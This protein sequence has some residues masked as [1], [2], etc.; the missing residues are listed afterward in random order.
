MHE[1]VMQ[2][3][4]MHALSIEN[5]GKWYLLVFFL[6]FYLLPLNFHP[7][8]MPDETRYAEISREMVQSGDWVVP[9]LLGLR[10]FEKPV[11]G[12]WLNNMSQ[13]VFGENS[14]S[15]R[16]IPALMTF[17]SA[18]C[19]YW[20]AMR[21]WSNPRKAFISAFIYLSSFLVFTIGTFN[22]LDPI[23]T[24]WL[25]A[26]MCAFY[27]AVTAQTQKSKLIAYIL[28]GVCSGLG[29]LTKGFLALAVPVIAAG[30]YMLLQRRFIELVKYSLISLVV[31]GVV[32]LPWA[33]LIYRAEEDFW[34]YF[35][36]VEHIKRFMGENAQHKEPPWF[37]IPILFYGLLPWF[38]LLPGSLIKGWKL[39]K[40]NNDQLYL[41]TWCVMPFLFFSASSGKLPTYILPV[42]A[43]LAL[44]LGNVLIEAVQAENF[45]SIRINSAI[46]F[47]LGGLFF[48]FIF[49]V[50]FTYIDSDY[51]YSEEEHW[52]LFVALGALCL[53]MLLSAIQ[54]L[55]PQRYWLLNNAVFIPVLLVFF[56]SLP[57]ELF[58]SKTPELFIH[59]HRE[60]LQ[61]SDIL[62]SDDVGIAT[63][64]AWD[65]KRSDIIMFG[66]SG[67]LDYGL[68]YPDAKGR[69]VEIEE[70]KHWLEIQRKDHS[71]ALLTR[72]PIE[73]EV[74]VMS[75]PDEV[76]IKED[77]FY[78]FIYRK[79]ES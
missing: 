17:L 54:F 32:C 13:L 72:E 15:A 65:L 10:Y 43:P 58:Y 38:G 4:S 9:R 64:L 63:G 11:A 62:M 68:H 60:L 59:E 31:A 8:W 71:I 45:R 78:L 67:E 42:F 66:Q 3:R 2:G 26:T 28:I 53:W 34:H 76:I 16:F 1:V 36:W 41:L 75:Q 24:V 5:N 61:S 33:L 44:L 46:N 20:L 14:F 12:Y 19:V 79:R 56:G 39:R 70:F 48:V 27:L 47:L 69:F 57:L 77:K 37:F 30:P 23:V 6:L 51:Q 74:K 18:M 7:L 40:E 49:S 55:K 21:M 22:V 29:V 73:P 25:T 50:G 35:F 52:K